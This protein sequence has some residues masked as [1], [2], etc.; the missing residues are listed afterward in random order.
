VVCLVKDDADIAGPDAPPCG[1]DHDEQND[2]HDRGQ[3]KAQQTP[4]G[5]LRMGEMIGHGMGFF[6]MGD[7]NR[8]Y[9]DDF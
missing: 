6:G 5:D 9:V 2:S 8:L 3:E 7:G 4:Y 1:E